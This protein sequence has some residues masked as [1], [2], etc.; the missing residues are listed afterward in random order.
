MGAALGFMRGNSGMDRNPERNRADY[1]VRVEGDQAPYNAPF[2]PG[3]GHVNFAEADENTLDM[4]GTAGIENRNPRADEFENGR[5]IFLD[6]GSVAREGD[7][8]H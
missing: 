4:R 8:F 2:Y 3:A 7:M 6:R 5:R 1:T